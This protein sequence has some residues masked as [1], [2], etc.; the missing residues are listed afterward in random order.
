VFGTVMV[1]RSSASLEAIRAVVAEWRT[2]LG[3]EHGF[4][5]ERVLVGD[6]GLFVMTVRF[7][8]RAA[9]QGLADDP[10]QDVWWRERMAPLLEGEPSWFDGEWHDV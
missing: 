2:E 4:V 1:A 5:D 10:R 9:Y 6:D 8:D 7:R 3:D